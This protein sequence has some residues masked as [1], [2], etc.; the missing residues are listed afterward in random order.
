MSNETVFN[1]D[2]ACG[3]CAKAV[4]AMLTKVDGVEDVATD[5]DNNLV[6]VT[7]SASAD[8][9]LEAIKKTGKTCSLKQ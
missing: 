5:V 8:V 4:T 3:G 1:V 7:G 6:A 9:M 2:M